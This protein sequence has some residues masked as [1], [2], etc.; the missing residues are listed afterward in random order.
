VP[1][2][3]TTGPVSWHDIQEQFKKYPRRLQFATFLLQ[4]GVAIKKGGLYVNEVG[5]TVAGVA[6]ASKVDRRIVARTISQIEKSARLKLLFKNVQAHLFM[7]NIG[8]FYKLGVISVMVE[9][10][11]TAGIVCK[12][13]CTLAEQNVSIRHITTD[14]PEICPRPGI[15][16]V[17]YGEVPKGLTEELMKIPGVGSVQIFGPG[18]E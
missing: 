12:V 8:Q 17:T 6:R 14:D 3:E 5:I 15:L 10:P 4:N 7:K 1:K 13:A 11:R 16:I 2:P 9:D 18:S